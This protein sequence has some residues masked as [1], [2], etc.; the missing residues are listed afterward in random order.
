ME[1]QNLS[2][3]CNFFNRSERSRISIQIHIN[4]DQLLKHCS[5]CLELG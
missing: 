3:I 1:E 4:Y 5:M 2:D